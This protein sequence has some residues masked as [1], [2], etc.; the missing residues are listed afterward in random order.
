M[1]SLITAAVSSSG[2]CPE[3][4]HPA[5]TRTARGLAERLLGMPGHCH[6]RLEPAIWFDDDAR[7]GCRALIHTGVT[8]TRQPLGLFLR[9][10]AYS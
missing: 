8:A 1:A 10:V 7:C 9:P 3:C 5:T 6:A 2:T 4:A